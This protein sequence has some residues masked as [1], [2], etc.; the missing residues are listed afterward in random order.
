MNSN[1][2]HDLHAKMK[3]FSLY[4]NNLEEQGQFF[5]ENYLVSKLAN[6]ELWNPLY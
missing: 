3:K 2:D 1:F 5:E 4:W 6:D